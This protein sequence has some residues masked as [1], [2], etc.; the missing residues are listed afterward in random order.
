M[1]GMTVTHTSDV[2]IGVIALA[3]A[4]VGGV[5]TGGAQ[6]LAQAMRHKRERDEAKIRAR[7]VARVV[8]YF[9]DIWESLLGHTR[10]QGRWWNADL[11]PVPGWADADLQ[12][13]AARCEKE[14]WVQIQ[15]ALVV[16]RAAAT[17]REA[18]G[19]DPDLAFDKSVLDDEKNTA[20]YENIRH[21]LKVGMAALSENFG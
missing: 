6:L 7:G 12:L 10:Q 9:L 17:M 3:G 8:S 21:V 2:T 20:V 4:V 11:E 1:L 14:Q 19:S 16:A 15:L 5:L 13:I 18:A